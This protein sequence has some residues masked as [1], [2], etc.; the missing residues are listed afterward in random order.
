MQQ[1]KVKGL[2]LNTEWYN[3]N[4]NFT[5]VENILQNESADLFLLPEMFATG[6]SME[7]EVV[8]DRSEETF[9][10]LKKMATKYGTALSGTAPVHEEGKFFNRMYFVTPTD[11]YFYDKR[12][13]FSYSGE[14][15]VYSK[16]S[17]RKVIEYKGLRFLLQVCY[18]LRFPVFSR[19]TDSYDV[20]LYLANW[21]VQRIDAWNTLLKARAIENQAYVIGINRT[22]KDGN[23]LVY[24]SSS[25]CFFADGTEVGS[26]NGG[27]LSCTLEKEKLQEFR[28]R[29][30]FLG[31]QDTFHITN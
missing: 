16:G 11:T 6:F 17:S 14:D 30:R 9:A 22:G 3:K 1:L 28:E 19:N 4:A 23:G 25:H 29:F 8:A 12:H 7:P 31:D 24:E 13:L 18:D 5:S 20:V 21:P 15:K 27:L 10:F 2:E 26:I